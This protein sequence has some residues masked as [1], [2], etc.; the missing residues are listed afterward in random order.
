MPNS[1]D[2]NQYSQETFL[3][4][5]QTNDSQI[6]GSRTLDQTSS[7]AHSPDTYSGSQMADRSN[8]PTLTNSPLRSSKL[9]RSLFFGAWISALLAVIGY[10]VFH[11]IQRSQNPAPNRRHGTDIRSYNLSFASN[12]GHCISIS[13]RVYNAYPKWIACCPIS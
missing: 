5:G 1:Q 13:D 10:G 3:T 6:T 2:H 4:S 8:P 7:E 11:F 9:W 12:C